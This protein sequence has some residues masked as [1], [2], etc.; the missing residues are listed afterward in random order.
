VKVLIVDQGRDRT[1][2]ASARALAASGWTVGAASPEPSLCSRSSAV[3]AWHP[4]VHTDEGEERFVASVDEVVARHGYDVVFSGWEAAIAALS[5]RRDQLSFPIGYGSHDGVMLAMDKGALA[6]VAEECGLG[7]PRTGP[8]TDELFADLGGP[9]IVK[10]ASQAVCG[11]EARDFDDPDAGAAYA[12]EIQAAGGEAIAQEMIRGELIAVSAVMGDDGIVT[13]AQQV[14]ELVWPQPIGVTARGVTV[15]IDSE[16]RSG[17]ERLLR[18]LSWRGLADIQ[19]LLP[20]DGRP[21]L[22]DLNG[23]LY[24]SIALAIRAGA[25]HPDA[26]A[27]VTAGLPVE[28]REGKPG[29]RYQWFSRDLRASLSSRRPLVEG[30][31]CLAIA[32]TASH[33][34]WSWREPLLAPRFLLE[35]TGRKTRRRLSGAR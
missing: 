31:R 24:G 35:Q 4:I 14:A 18:R 5:A 10:P 17:V 12:R 9:V 15:P 22:I 29:A 16:L 32:A 25:N 21:R 26:W 6:P 3:S 27:R 33:S 30:A 8:A 2:V 19:F 7:V 13:I 34:L 28:P 1:P 23:R 11:M 20:E